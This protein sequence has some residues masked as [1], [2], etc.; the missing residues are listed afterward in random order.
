MPECMLNVFIIFII[1]C[2]G[3]FLLS[4][5]TDVPPPSGKI[6]RGEGGGTSVHRLV[7][8]SVVRKCKSYSR[9]RAEPWSNQK[10]GE[11]GGGQGSTHRLHFTR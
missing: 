10:T 11:R 3:L 6:G 4:L 8:A 9:S 5:C 2:F 7:F 1:Y